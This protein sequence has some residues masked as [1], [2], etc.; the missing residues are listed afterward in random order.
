MNLAVIMGNIGTDLELKQTNSGKA[1]CNF[2]VATSD[3]NDTTN[4]HDVV[5]WE[6][7]AENIC[8]F[9]SKGSKILINGMIQQREYEHDGQKRK[10]T[11]IKCNRFE[12][13]EKKTADKVESAPDAGEINLDDIP[14]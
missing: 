1:V 2:R 3:G 9:F 12:F 4:W 10:A 8:K 13:V 7:D 14:F 6:K 11:E 5:A